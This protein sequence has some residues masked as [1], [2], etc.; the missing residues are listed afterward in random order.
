MPSTLGTMVFWAHSAPNFST[1]FIRLQ[2]AASRMAY[3]TKWKWK[4]YVW[5]TTLSVVCL[6]Q[7]TVGLRSCLLVLELW[8]REVSV[9][10]D[11]DLWEACCHI[12]CSHNCW[13]RAALHHFLCR[14]LFTTTLKPADSINVVVLILN[15]VLVWTWSNKVCD[16]MW[17]W[18]VRERF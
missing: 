8:W 17:E 2:V 9:N 14:L 7:E 4:H 6:F 15:I 3:T 5:M 1:S 12:L 18:T 16:T 13:S 10:S 11:T